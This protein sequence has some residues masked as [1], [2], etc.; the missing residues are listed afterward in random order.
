M[1]FKKT[2]ADGDILLL[3]DSLDLDVCDKYLTGH[4]SNLVY[5]GLCIS[6]N[7]NNHLIIMLSIEIQGEVIDGCDH[8]LIW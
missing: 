4:F 2:G 7:G 3:L 8:I 1:G 6:A 5:E